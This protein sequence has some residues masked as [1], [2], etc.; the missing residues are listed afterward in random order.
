MPNTLPTFRPGLPAAQ[1][2]RS[3]QR[4]A[5]FYDQARRC[6]LLWFHEVF[7]RELYRELGHATMEQYATERLGFPRHRTWHFLRLARDMD[8]LPPLHEAVVSG[9]LEWTKA[10]EVGR[11]ATPETAA[12][13]VDTARRQSRKQ[14]RETIRKAKK[15]AMGHEV[16][17]LPL[18]DSPTGTAPAGPPPAARVTLT[19][20]LDP[21]DL[22]RLEAALDA[23]RINGD[24]PAHAT[25][26]EAILLACDALACGRAE[27]GD[28]LRRR[29]RRPPRTVVLYRCEA[30]EKT[31]VVT[32]RGRRPVPR[33]AADALLEDA[34]IQRQGRNRSTIPPSTRAKVLARDGHRCQAPGC[35]NTRFLELHHITPRH[36][37]GDNTATN[38]ITLCGRCH[39]FLHEQG[40]PLANRP[41]PTFHDHARGSPA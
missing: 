20:A 15:R 4:A 34:V 29:H 39:R 18:A 17:E 8:R 6:T 30:C 10:Q 19:L 21:V 36:R 9:Q 32:S 35:R 11:V 16:P 38:L 7:H 12:D 37:G 27:T 3:L 14:L 1:V 26:E 24:I 23:A 28:D 13:W 33:P 5:A 22:A 2:D 31:E 41:L 25:R 40:A